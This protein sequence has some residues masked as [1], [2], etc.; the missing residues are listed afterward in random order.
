MRVKLIGQRPPQPRFASICV[1][2][3]DL[4]LRSVQ[5]SRKVIVGSFRSFQ[6][7]LSWNMAM[8]AE[9]IY[10]WFSL[11]MYTRTCMCVSAC[12]NA[13]V[14]ACVRILW[15]TLPYN[16]WEFSWFLTK[17]ISAWF[18]SQPLAF[19]YNLSFSSDARWKL[20]SKRIRSGNNKA[21]NDSV[22]DIYSNSI[23]NVYNDLY[24]Y[25]CSLS[26]TNI[27]IYIYTISKRMMSNLY[28]II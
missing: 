15:Q 13:C 12:I 23:T 17:D 25:V 6:L 11:S 18:S 26:S 9:Y 4:N 21:S 2:R 22:G 1:T 8:S 5:G 28:C 20:I 3:R 19:N 7:S 24:E 14:F 27:Y 16:Y 10:L